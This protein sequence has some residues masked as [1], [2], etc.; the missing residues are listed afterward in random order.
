MASA[1]LAT[2]TLPQTAPLVRTGLSSELQVSNYIIDL[3][4]F[5]WMKCPVFKFNM[6]K[7][8]RVFCFPKFSLIP[9]IL[10]SLK[11][12]TI[13]HTY[14]DVTYQSHVWPLP[15]TP[16]PRGRLVKSYH[17]SFHKVSYIC[18]HSSVPSAST[19]FR[20][21]LPLFWALSLS[22]QLF[23]PSSASAHISHLHISSWRIFL[24]TSYHVSTY[25]P[26]VSI[27]MPTA[28]RSLQESN[29]TQFT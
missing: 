16:D 14:L 25:F 10:V 4:I 12:T 9:N 17:F 27:L 2:G 28:W 23:L 7:F 18:S 20:P 29:P 1:I 8:K 26:S 13:A 15:L 6:L 19:Q 5:I 11:D 3:D 24:N 22:S 21:R